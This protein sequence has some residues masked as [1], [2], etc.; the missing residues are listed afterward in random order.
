MM[1]LPAVI[2]PAPPRHCPQLIRIFVGADA[3]ARLRAECA[4][5]IDGDF[6]PSIAWNQ[7][8]LNPVLFRWPVCDKHVA[9]YGELPANKLRLLLAALIRDGALVAAGVNTDGQLHTAS[10]PAQKRIAA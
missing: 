1:T 6:P 5:L 4:Y 7:T 2:P 8:H 10:D 9:I 3:E